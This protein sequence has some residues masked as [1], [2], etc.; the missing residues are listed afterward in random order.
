MSGA[1]SYRPTHR[2]A[3]IDIGATFSA[4]DRLERV[5]CVSRSAVVMAD[6]RTRDWPEGW[7]AVRSKILVDAFDTVLDAVLSR[8]R[9]SARDHHVLPTVVSGRGGGG[10]ADW[11]RRLDLECRPGVVEVFAP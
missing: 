3:I 1:V 7:F 8:P 11:H 6:E 4:A 2:V 10:P 9:E 5:R